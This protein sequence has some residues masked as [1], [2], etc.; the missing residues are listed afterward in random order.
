L[1]RF[2]RALEVQPLHLALPVDG[3]E[4]EKPQTASSHGYSPPHERHAHKGVRFSKK[5]LIFKDMRNL[6]SCSGLNRLNVQ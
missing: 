2:R 5:P 3:I 1:T 4:Q 6:R